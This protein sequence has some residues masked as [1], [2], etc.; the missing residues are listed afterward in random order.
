MRERI[1]TLP[2]PLTVVAWLHIGVVVL[3]A[4][5][6]VL[7]LWERDVRRLAGGI[8]AAG[9]ELLALGAILQKSSQVRKVILIL[10]WLCAPSLLTAAFVVLSL[11][12]IA[13]LILLL[14]SIVVGVTLW[15]LMSRDARKYFGIDSVSSY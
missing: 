6:L 8:A 5:L 11:F 9:G 10:N 4:F 12:P 1:N 14:P 15:G 2:I 3:A 13:G 7:S